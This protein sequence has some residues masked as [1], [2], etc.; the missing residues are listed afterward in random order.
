[1]INTAH[2]VENSRTIRRHVVAGV[3]ITAVL[4]GGF[5][6]WAALASLSGAV[7]ASGTV[8][9]EGNAKRVQHPEGGVVGAI[10]VRDGQ[11]VAAGELVLRLDE[12]I[13]RANLTV[14]ETQL[15]EL[16][17]RRARLIAER[18]GQEAMAE[19]ASQN[20]ADALLAAASAGEAS[21]FR[22]RRE[23]RLGQIAQLRERT[24]QL[25]EEARGLSAQI[26]AKDGELRL[27]GLELMDVSGLQKQGLVPLTRLR[28]L[29]R[30]QTR[31]NGERG[32]LQADLARSKGRIT[33]TNLQILQIDQDFR[34]EVIEHL[35]EAEAKWGELVQKKIAS[36]EQLQRVELRA[37][38]AGIVHQLSAHTVG[39]VIGPSETVM[40]IVPNA[41]KLTVDG[42]VKPADIDQLH[43]GQTAKVRLAAFNQ[44]TTPEVMGQVTR[45]SADLIQE[46]ETGL[47]YYT[48]RVAL[49]PEEMQKLGDLVLLPGMPA[50]IYVQTGDRTAMNYIVKPLR[51]QLENALRED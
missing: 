10:L 7:I 28:T 38:I 41:E 13:T 20:E 14:V 45:I 17:A 39:G 12:T 1:M 15:A 26:S 2:E 47:S 18:D 36:S 9:V 31:L 27:I 29:Q 6:S 11:A 30:E 33:E 46:K 25:D 32:Q 48:I 4:F 43:T 42:K 40:M 49:A 34:T 19:T 5:G 21:L 22:S 37:P 50:E 23:G 24:A 3:V 51:D 44:R 16:E 35:R 8:V